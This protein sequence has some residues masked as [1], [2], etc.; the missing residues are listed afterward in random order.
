[1]VLLIDVERVL[2]HCSK[3]AVRSGFWKPDKWPD[4][5]KLPNLATIA[6]DHADTG[7]TLTQVQ[8]LI[9]DSIANKLY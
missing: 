8:A 3:W 4:T 5:S 7:E 1:M 9:D 6:R 2:F